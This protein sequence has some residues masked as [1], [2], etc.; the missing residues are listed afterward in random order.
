MLVP[1]THKAADNYVLMPYHTIDKFRFFLQVLG[2][3]IV[4]G[5][6][7]MFAVYSVAVTDESNH[8]WSIK[9]R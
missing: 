5:S 3:N 7:K 4:K 2:A 8:S 9:R 6:S 1:N